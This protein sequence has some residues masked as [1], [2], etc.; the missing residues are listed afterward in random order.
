MQP[1]KPTQN[2]F[3][4]SFNGKFRDNGLY[5]HTYRYQHTQIL[6]LELNNHVVN[7]RKMRY[8]YINNLFSCGRII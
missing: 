6:C 5:K 8:K 2:A 4:E 3:V 1:E 7:A